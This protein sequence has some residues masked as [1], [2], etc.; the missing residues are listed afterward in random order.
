VVTDN[1]R[2]ET[3]S[4]PH[5]L[6][7]PIKPTTHFSQPLLPDLGGGE[8]GEVGGSPAVWFLINLSFPHMAWSLLGSSLHESKHMIQYLNRVMDKNH[9]TISIVTEKAFDT[10]HDKNHDE[11][12]NGKIIPEYYKGYM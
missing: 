2:L 1:Q 11:T 4:L 10:L 8:L 3:L 9:I 7:P 5:G 6:G 12:K